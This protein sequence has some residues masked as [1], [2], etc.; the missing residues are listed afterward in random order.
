M[1]RDMARESA[2][3]YD[4]HAKSESHFKN[5]KNCESSLKRNCSLIN[6]HRI[7]G[8]VPL[9]EGKALWN[10]TKVSYKLRRTHARII[11]RERRERSTSICRRQLPYRKINFSWNRSGSHNTLY[12]ESHSIQRSTFRQESANLTLR[13]KL[14]LQKTIFV[15]VEFFQAATHFD[16]K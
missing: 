16:N 12:R 11:S 2:I 13:N 7:L 10:A 14:L 5:L 8:T 1:E 6:I 4:L 15:C 9:A 3:L